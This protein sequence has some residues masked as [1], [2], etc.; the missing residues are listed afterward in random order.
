MHPETA[1][2]E[3]NSHVAGSSWGIVLLI[4]I[5]VCSLV[6]VMAYRR[7]SSLRETGSSPSRD[8]SFAD[9]LRTAREIAWIAVPMIVIASFGMTAEPEEFLSAFWPSTRTVAPLPPPPPT[10][11][12]GG[13]ETSQVGVANVSTSGDR[14]RPLWM[15]APR[16]VDGDCQRIVITSQQYS[17]REEAEPE[18]RWKAVKLV[19]EDLRRI[20][21]GSFR[22]KEWWPKD[23][24]VIA[25]AVK[26]RYD[27]VTERDFGRFT[28][29]MHRVS[30]LVELSPAVR[31]EFLPAWRRE[32]RSFRIMLVAVVLS[33]FSMVAAA[34][35]MYFR[36]EAITRGR[37]QGRAAALAGGLTMLY[38]ILFSTAF[39]RGHLW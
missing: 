2:V 27:E 31:T 22:P 16:I 3:L 7:R 33:M 5:A 38:L 4:G 8:W 9:R 28:H 39:S 23:A 20:Q 36:L 10:V 13:D 34:G 15:N 11:V 35:L 14:I 6:C 32:V 1:P 19:Q 25:N 21:T 37:M 29:P 18:L 26:E 12:G 17:T 30:W 24:D